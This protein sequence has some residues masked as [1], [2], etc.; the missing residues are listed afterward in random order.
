MT[1][2]SDYSLISFV[3]H[4]ATRIEI[5]RHHC[6]QIIASLRG[7]FACNIG[8]T[9]LSDSLGVVVNQSVPHS[10]QA[11]NASALI[12]FIDAESY[13]G[14]QMKALLGEQPFL[15]IASLLTETQW[16][17]I[18]AEGNQHLPKP[19]LKTF[20]DEV[21]NSI[22]PMP[23]PLPDVTMDARVR[24]ALAFIET[25]LD[26]GV[27][28]EELADLMALSPERARHLLAQGAGMPFS[29][30]LLWKRIKQV[31]VT[32]LQGRH[33]LTEAAL[34]FGFADQSHFCRVFKRIFGLSPKH[35]LKNSRF[36]QFL[37]PSTE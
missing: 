19:E 3:A 18:C 26:T 6:F 9:V 29:Q 25:R 1:P 11:G 36:V 14:W 4:N 28:L 16:R 34:Q 32:V 2:E 5:H 15:E 31:I 33:S 7:T 30:Y 37:N 17:R 12:F 27:R 20:A 10:C 35:L 24:A 23:A 13:Q 21:L 8:G 22:L